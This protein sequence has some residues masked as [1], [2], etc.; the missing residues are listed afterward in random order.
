MIVSSDDCMSPVMCVSR[1]MCVFPVMCVSRVMCVFPVMC[2]SPVMYS[3]HANSYLAEVPTC[4]FF[5]Q[6]KLFYALPAGIA[7]H[8]H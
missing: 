2:V 8:T 3:Y 4:L 6:E 1:V 7:Y 5:L